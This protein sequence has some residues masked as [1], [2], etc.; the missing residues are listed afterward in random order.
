M[1]VAVICVSLLSGQAS[2]GLKSYLFIK[3][4]LQKAKENLCRIVGIRA[5]GLGGVVSSEQRHSCFQSC[6]HRVQSCA[7]NGRTERGSCS[8]ASDQIS[9]G[10]ACGVAGLP[11]FV[12]KMKLVSCVQTSGIGSVECPGSRE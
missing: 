12:S 10:D 5:R 2:S 4:S 11:V 1:L 7:Q 3:G 9:V 8:D 6:F